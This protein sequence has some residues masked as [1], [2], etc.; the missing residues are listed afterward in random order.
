M[1]SPIEGM[2]G[3]NGPVESDY[4][5]M[6]P[7]DPHQSEEREPI[8]LGG[9]EE[10]DPEVAA[11]L[12]H[13]SDLVVE[14]V[15][16][17]V[18]PG[19]TPLPEGGVVTEQFYVHDTERAARQ[20]EKE[21]RRAVA[22]LPPADPHAIRFIGVQ[23]GFPQNIAAFLEQDNAARWAAENPE[24]RIWPVRGIT[25]GQPH[26]GFVLPARNVL[27]TEEMAKETG[28]MEETND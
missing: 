3:D 23:Y 1:T 11:L 2:Q 9:N 25:L 8:A 4:E 13:A 16:R 18:E 6:R 5:P 12:E 22:S 27:M 15:E 7:D 10:P 26:I 19:Y 20:W 28:R 24:R 17:R 14:A 21:D